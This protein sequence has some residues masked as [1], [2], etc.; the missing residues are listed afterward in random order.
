[1]D[2]ESPIIRSH[3]VAESAV[4]RLKLVQRGKEGTAPLIGQERYSLATLLRDA[5]S[6][7]GNRLG[8]GGPAVEPPTDEEVRRQ[9]AAQIQ[10]GL[11]VEPGRES[12]LIDVVFDDPIPSLAASIANAVAAAYVELR[13]REQAAREGGTPVDPRAALE[14]VR[15]QLKASEAA[16]AEARQ[17]PGWADARKQREQAAGRVQKLTQDLAKARTEL[18]EAKGRYEQARRPTS[19]GATLPG[20]AEAARTSA[21]VRDLLAQYKTLSAK[22]QELSGRV[23]DRHPDLITARAQL[24]Q[25][26]RVLRPEVGSALRQQQAL[27]EARVSEI[28][29]LLAA[30][31]A[32]LDV[33]PPEVREVARL[34]EEVARNRKLLAEAQARVQ[35]A[36]KKKSE[37]APIRVVEAAKTPERPYRGSDASDTAVWGGAIG[38]CLGVGLAVFRQRL[39]RAS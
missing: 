29:A 12:G 21:T 4:D 3:A 37:P 38:F 22:L 31:Q 27:A 15:Q 34:E 11:S 14:E 6:W 20:A 1:L 25:L 19:E 35:E 26:E 28:E 36:Q 13:L 5:G 8:N 16:L 30:Q 2:T 7:L 10:S 9:L 17:R 18:D 33:E 32:Q 23:L 39:R 24:Q